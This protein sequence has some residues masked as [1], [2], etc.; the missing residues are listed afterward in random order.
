MQAIDPRFHRDAYGAE[1]TLLIGKDRQIGF[2]N[3]GGSFGSSSDPRAH[4]GLGKIDRIDRIIV[5]WP[6]GMIESFPGGEVDRV[7]ILKA[8][9]SDVAKTK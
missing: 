6:G 8:G 2:I 7:V 4:F 3:P 9:G 5:R 1:V